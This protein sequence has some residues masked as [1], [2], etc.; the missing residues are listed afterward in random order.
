MPSTMQEFLDKA[1]NETNEATRSKA[2][3]KSELL[4]KDAQNVEKT[5]KGMEKII[6]THKVKGADPFIDA[7]KVFISQVD[8][9]FNRLKNK[10]FS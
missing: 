4:W 5:L 1:L 9:E 2:E 7:F 3:I 8:L 10:L 6:K